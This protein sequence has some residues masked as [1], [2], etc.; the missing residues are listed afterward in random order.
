MVN[1]ID[2]SEWQLF[3]DS[4][5]S[6]IKKRKVG[7]CLIC[8]NNG[9]FADSHTLTEQIIEKLTDP[10]AK[11]KQVY[12]FD[13]GIKGYSRSMIS[14]SKYTNPEEEHLFYED[15]KNLFRVNISNAG[16][17]NFICVKCEGK[18]DSYE[19]HLP[20]I[21]SYRMTP[22]DIRDLFFEGMLQNAHQSSIGV[23]IYAFF[24]ERTG[25]FNKDITPFERN[26]ISMK[27]ASKKVFNY[28][29]K[30]KILWDSLDYDVLFNVK[31]G[32]YSL[33]SVPSL[34]KN[35][36]S[37]LLLIVVIPD[38]LGSRLLL[39]TY[40]ETDFKEIFKET[41]PAK[42]LLETLSYISNVS[43]KGIFTPTSLDVRPFC[44]MFLH[45]NTVNYESRQ[46]L[47]RHLV[48]NSKYYD[49]GSLILK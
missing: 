33:I 6:S 15:L 12:Y 28:H 49:N 36:V 11:K 44:E 9:R 4:I 41:E 8:S 48:N 18:L 38:K 35:G 25:V 31:I 24:K 34:N 39:L 47:L 32:V 22:E 21:L 10:N 1:K 17:F 2:S 45:V 5:S 43:F 26:L 7:E 42:I 29:R 13:D 19:D 16:V 30:A 3:I 20:E 37:N 46:T 23:D 14:K 27:E 40:E